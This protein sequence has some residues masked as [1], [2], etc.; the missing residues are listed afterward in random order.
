MYIYIYI[1]IAYVNIRLHKLYIQKKYKKCAKKMS[2]RVKKRLFLTFFMAVNSSN[3]SGRLTL[4]V[5][6]ISELARG[7]S[8]AADGGFLLL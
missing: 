4:L 1:I 6:D 7:G 3:T 5:E 8:P 2:K